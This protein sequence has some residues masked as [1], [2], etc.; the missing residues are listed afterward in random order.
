MATTRQQTGSRSA[1]AKGQ[2]FAG[3]GSAAAKPQMA[4]AVTKPDEELTQAPSEALLA[5]S[6]LA[7]LVYDALLEIGEAAK[8]SEITLEINNPRIT[9][10]VVRRVLNDSPRF[11]SVDRLWTLAARYLD[12]SRPTERNLQE[13]ISSAGKPLSTAE[14]ATELSAVYNRPSEVYFSLLAKTL[15]NKERYFKAGN[16]GYG[17][18]S[19]LP[20]VD[21][22]EESD[23]LFDNRLTRAALAPFIEAA[24]GVTWSAANY[25]E[26]TFTIAQRLGDRP[27]PHRVAGI[28]AW[29]SLR[30]AYEPLK[31]LL[32][33]LADAR[34]VWMTSPAGGRWI[35]R[36]LADRLE[37]ILEERAAALGD[38]VEEAAPEPEPVIPVA[39][40]V[41]VA[42]PVEA[43]AE[44]A[45]AE[46]AEAPAAAPPPLA[47]SDEDLRALA[48]IVA[49]RAAPVEVSE[50]LG[51]QYEVVPGDPSFRADMETLE[52]RLKQDDRFL[53]V[54]A[55][56]F[57]EPNSLPLF[58]YSIPEFL[59]F[60]DLQFVSL[61][62]EIMDE[63]IEDEGFVGT[64][65]QDLLNPLAQDAGDDEGHYTGPEPSDPNVARFVVKAH[66][67]E[68]GTFPLCQVPGGF[69]PDDAPV[70]EV[71]IRDPNGQTHDV[72][73]N[74]EQR[75]AFNLFGLY[76]FLPADS[77]AAFLLHRGARPFEYRFEPA[78]EDD[79][80]V[81]VAS[82]R[83]SEL[84]GLKEAA[85]E[86]GDMAT[87]DI[88]CEVLAHYPK[89]LDF[90]QLITEV[91]I[92]RRV[93][94]RKLASILSNYYC[95]VQKAGTGQWRFDAKKRDLGTDRA[96]RKYLKR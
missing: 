28:L 83:I 60:P 27:L 70:V 4:V 88:A 39:A 59:A 87:F 45:P 52:S 26:A 35:T 10:P 90:V 22:D 20:L 13:V 71:V 85:E 63:E 91:N 56:R 82:T 18:M 16:G 7:D 31:H 86:G 5:D 34:L 2:Q 57:R 51:L 11:L 54:G 55:G 62:G 65:R 19:W 15:Q 53:Y 29:L 49:E 46:P 77:G 73:V 75:L 32:A 78:G 94:R 25:A 74:N 30:D 96:K 67:K 79:P 9:Y 42:P 21:A 48:A 8:A 41:A 38:E 89:G 23:I 76:E 37:S 84:I 69:F 6:Y 64:L 14:M 50:L 44:A 33:C 17:L 1:G 58:V 72:I 43:L 12:T 95:F 47:V 92:V 80:E 36:S 66:H 93:T 61:D 68:I 3:R 81:F 40:P 24:S